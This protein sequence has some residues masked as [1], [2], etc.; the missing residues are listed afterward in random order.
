MV[1]TRTL[2]ESA[3]KEKQEMEQLTKL[4]TMKSAQI[5]VQSRM[6]EKLHTNCSNQNSSMNVAIKELPDVISET[7]L[8]L[9]NGL[10]DS[11]PLCVEIFLKTVDGDTMTLETWSIGLLSESAFDP[12]CSRHLVYTLYN[13]LGVLLK[14]LVSVTRVIPAYRYSRQQSHDSYQIHHRI[15]AGEPQVHTLGKE[16]KELQ[17]G[18]V[19]M[20]IGTIQVTVCYRTSMT[21]T[22]QQDPIMLKSDHFRKEYSPRHNQIKTPN[23]DQSRKAYIMDDWTVG[24]FSESLEEKV[25]K[26]NL[27]RIPEFPKD[28]FIKPRKQ[29]EYWPPHMV[30]SNQLA[31]TKLDSIKDSDNS[32]VSSCVNNNVAP[33]N[34]N[35]NLG[36]VKNSTSSETETRNQINQ[37]MNT[38]SNETI[39]DFILGQSAKPQSPE[40]FCRRRSY[41]TNPLQFKPAAFSDSNPN[42]ELALFYQRFLRAPSLKLRSDHNNINNHLSDIVEQIKSFNDRME[43]FDR[44]V[45][46]LCRKDDDSE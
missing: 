25:K 20:P 13:R 17:I 7:K 14:S 31:K 46:D 16:Y 38:S 42:I 3:E 43:E 18:Q 41:D 44:V 32:V 29:A 10:C 9:S 37:S 36:N 4:M 11:V 34:T 28:T 2:T 8:V 5:I 26:L 35:E 15:Y 24:A 21:L 45:L 39:N 1:D 6:G 40:D 33:S 19:S 30:P 12:F 22:S 27:Y 23:D